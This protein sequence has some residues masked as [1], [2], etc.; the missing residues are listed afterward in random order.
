MGGSAECYSDLQDPRTGNA[1]RHL[2]LEVPMIALCAMLC[3]AEGCVD[4]GAFVKANSLTSPAMFA[5][6]RRKT[7][8]SLGRLRLVIHANGTTGSKS[9]LGVRR[10]KAAFFS[11]CKS[12]PAT[13]AP[14]GGMDRRVLAVALHEGVGA[15]PDVKVGDHSCRTRLT[16]ASASEAV[17]SG[18]AC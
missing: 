12:H 6:L 4:T 11:G 2:L 17:M 14:A 5:S 1:T 18:R 9:A 15:A 7:Q 16:A 10:G 13:I 8:T 3:G